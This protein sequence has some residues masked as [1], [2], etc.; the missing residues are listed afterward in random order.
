MKAAQERS[1]ATYTCYNT[2]SSS[3]K[4]SSHH[5]MDSASGSSIN[6]GCGVDRHNRDEVAECD[7]TGQI[8]MDK[9]CH[10][11]PMPAFEK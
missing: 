3:D 1:G 4:C 5:K 11:Q 10:V 6:G 7:R 8:L 9:T 2:T